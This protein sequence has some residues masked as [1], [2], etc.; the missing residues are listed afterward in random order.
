[1]SWVGKLW[2]TVAALAVTGMLAQ[3]SGPAGKKRDP[4]AAGTPPAADV[5]AAPARL[6]PPPPADA[7]RA[8]DCLLVERDGKLTCADA[9][10]LEDLGD[11]GEPEPAPET[12]ASR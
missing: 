3:C 1:M 9:E 8:R 7:S 2:L 6:P 4:A 12:P 5:L 10:S 11:L